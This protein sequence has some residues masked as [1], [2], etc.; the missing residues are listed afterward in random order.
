MDET[1]KKQDL[2]GP[3]LNGASRPGLSPC[4]KALAR[5]CWAEEMAFVSYGVRL[6]I[7]VNDM[8][9]SHEPGLMNRLGKCLP[10]RGQPSAGADQWYSL[11]TVANRSRH[12]PG[13]AHFLYRGTC[14]IAQARDM[15]G[16]L[17]SWESDLH[18][19]IAANTR[20]RLFVHAGVVGWQGQ[21][22]VI[23]GR[24]FSG[25]T[26]L[27]AALVRAGAVYLSDEYA[28][29]DAAGLV[30]PYPKLL[31]VRDEQGNPAGRYSA[32]ALGGSTGTEPL[33]VGLVLSCRYEADARWQPRR[34]SSGQALLALLDN[35]VQVRHQPQTTLETL[36]Q[37]VTDTPTF[38]SRRGETGEV[39]AW[40]QSYNQ[41]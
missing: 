3:L 35:T 9:L 1:Q 10:P 25:K 26:T 30:Y 8:A 15:A 4:E 5:F 17:Q 32:E 12:M 38:G 23:P 39:V 37:V 36:R 41:F 11:A 22:V 7:R 6:G 16:I 40:L 19:Q 33:P 20:E 13:H 2:S 27:T 29:F 14:R 28:V 34:L 21:A 31:S 24:S 18:G